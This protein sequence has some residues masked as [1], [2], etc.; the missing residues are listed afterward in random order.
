MNTVQLVSPRDYFRDQVCSAAQTLKLQL[1]GDVEFYL[2][3]LLCE[4]INPAQ[5]SI[6]E[7]MA[8]LDTPLAMMLKKAVESSPDI[9]IKVY[10]RLGDTSLYFAGY[11][12]DFFN[13]KTYDVGYYINMGAAAYG[14]TSALMRSHKNDSHFSK[15]YLSM[16]QDFRS[17]VNI[18]AE[19]SEST[20][21]SKDRDLLTT[22]TRWQQT[23][24]SKLRRIL[25]EEGI[26]PVPL[27]NKDPQ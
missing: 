18:V 19:V 11:F 6:D 22:Y 7:D 4:F 1:D 27:S 12:Q 13:R 23:Q 14:Q 2:V 10:K 5:L 26:I 17:L 25:E 3:N 8:V 21:L 15:I 20:P 16:A 24:S 9:Q